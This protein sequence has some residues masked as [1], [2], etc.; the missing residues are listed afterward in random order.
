VRDKKPGGRLQ[1][2]AT[3][4]R[5]QGRDGLNDLEPRMVS[6]IGEELPASRIRPRTEQPDAQGKKNSKRTTD[7]KIEARLQGSERFDPPD[8]APL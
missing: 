7:A 2:A 6:H 1:V 8:L 5:D 3:G 4:A